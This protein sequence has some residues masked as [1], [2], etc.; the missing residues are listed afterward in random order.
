[1]PAYSVIVVFVDKDGDEFPVRVFP[2]VD[3][4]NPCPDTAIIASGHLTARRLIESGDFRP[5]GALS[6]DRIEAIA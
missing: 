3:K 4:E 2:Y 1:M 6:C 5:N